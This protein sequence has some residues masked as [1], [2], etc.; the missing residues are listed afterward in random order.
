MT[1]LTSFCSCHALAILSDLIGPI[2]SGTVYLEK[3]ASRG[4]AMNPR[5]SIDGGKTYQE[6]PVT[7][8]VVN[9]QG[10]EE[11]RVATADMYTHIMWN[12]DGA[13]DVGKEVLVSYRVQ[14][15]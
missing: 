8:V 7:Y 13:L 11:H 14:V 2:P 10:V 5:F 1:S 12:V 9:A 6:A 4:A 3:T 15:K